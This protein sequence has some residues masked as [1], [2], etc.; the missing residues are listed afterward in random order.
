MSDELDR[1]RAL[2]TAVAAYRQATNTYQPVW[3]D[4]MTN[5]D[6]VSDDPNVREAYMGVRA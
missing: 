5:Y 6:T 2:A 4:I 3:E 1:L